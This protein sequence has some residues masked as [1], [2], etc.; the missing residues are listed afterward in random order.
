MKTRIDGAGRLVIPKALRERYGFEAGVEIEI[1]TI[2][3][4]ITLVPAVPV[5]RILR[6]GRVAALDTGAGS[7]PMEI[8]AVDRIRTRRL[9]PSMRIADPA[10]L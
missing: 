4:G 7:A 1:V 10:E 2:P 5:R 9:A 6:R 8:F 3:D